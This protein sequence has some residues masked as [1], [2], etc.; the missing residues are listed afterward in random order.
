MFDSW[1]DYSQF[2]DQL[3]GLV[4]GLE[5]VFPIGKSLIP[6]VKDF[7]R[8]LIPATSNIWRFYIYRGQFVG[9]NPAVILA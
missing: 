3:H 9:Y 8:G 7:F 4:G 5:H 1:D 6:S 2:I